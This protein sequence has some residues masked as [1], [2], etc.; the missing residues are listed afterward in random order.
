[1]Q[2]FNDCNE[3][4]PKINRNKM[5]TKQQRLSISHDQKMRFT[6]KMYVLLLLRGLYSRTIN[7]RIMMPAI[8][9]ILQELHG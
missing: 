9:S 2:R 1:M 7:I 4:S 5:Y 8:I 3:V 6:L